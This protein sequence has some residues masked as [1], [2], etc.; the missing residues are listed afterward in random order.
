MEASDSNVCVVTVVEGGKRKSVALVEGDN[1]LLGLVRA[2]LP[3]EFFC[4]TGKCTTCR[5]RMEIPAGSAPMASETEQYRLGKEAMAAGYRLACQVFVAGPL[6][7]YLDDS[8]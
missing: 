5:L 4:T 2:N 1:L 6:T 3:V 7:V 8:R